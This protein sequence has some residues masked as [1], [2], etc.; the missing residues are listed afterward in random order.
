MI[1]SQG[2]LIFALCF[3]IGF[4]V[5]I[6]LSYKKDRKLHQKNYKDLWNVAVGFVAFFT[7]LIL[8]KYLLSK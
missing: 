8:L 2:Q 1:F 5:L 7:L 6:Y 4:S 3:V